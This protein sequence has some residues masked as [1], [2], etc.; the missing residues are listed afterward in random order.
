MDHQNVLEP[1]VEK[2]GVQDLKGI[3]F[4]VTVIIKSA[5]QMIA[6]LILIARN[7]QLKVQS[8]PKE[9]EQYAN[10]MIRILS[11]QTL[12]NTMHATVV[13]V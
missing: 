5:Y 2:E 13:M 11:I 7:T 4:I 10:K 8:I 1:N 9:G 6:V 12:G 3:L